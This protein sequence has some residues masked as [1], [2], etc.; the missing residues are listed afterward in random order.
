MAENNFSCQFESR[1]RRDR[2]HQPELRS[3]PQLLF[4]ITT[5]IN[6]L[7]EHDD[8]PVVALLKQI[9]YL[10]KLRQPLQREFFQELSDVYDDV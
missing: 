2:R 7:R 10:N 5:Y 8:E 9:Y 1:E 6:L 4:H 3:D